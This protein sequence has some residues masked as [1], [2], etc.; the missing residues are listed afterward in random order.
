MG[1]GAGFLAGG[2]TGGGHGGGIDQTGHDS[3]FGGQPP[4]LE[5]VHLPRMG[6][7][8]GGEPALG[9]DG[10]HGAGFAQFALAAGECARAGFLG[11]EQDNFAV[12]IE[13]LAVAFDGDV[14]VG[15]IRRVA[16][17]RGEG[18][19]MAG[20]GGEAAWVIEREFHSRG[21]GRHAE[22]AGVGMILAWC[23]RA[24]D[25]EARR[26][27]YRGHGPTLCRILADG[28]AGTWAVKKAA[29]F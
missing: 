16:H 19:V 27:C 13:R 14:R 17:G 5:S 10:R 21:W 25:G 23:R 11:K 1:G 24:A 7:A 26:A 6:L 12:V 3:G 20:R 28:L 8:F 4:A 18:V 22:R 2:F 29:L 15:E 9:L